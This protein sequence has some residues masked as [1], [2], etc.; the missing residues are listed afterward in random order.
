MHIFLIG[1]QSTWKRCTKCIWSIQV[2][3]EYKQKGKERTNH[4]SKK[5]FSP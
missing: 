2:V 4:N 5:K 3:A 1:K